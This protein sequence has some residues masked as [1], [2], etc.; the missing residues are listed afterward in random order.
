[1]LSLLHRYLE[2]Y[3][4][5]GRTEVQSFIED[6]EGQVQQIC[7][8]TGRRVK[9]A[10]GKKGNLCISKSI[11]TVYNVKSVKNPACKV[12]S[13]ELRKHKVVVACNKVQKR[14]LPVHYEKY[15]DQEP[16]NLTCM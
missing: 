14:C 9:G 7:G 1:M 3:H 15:S 13:A 5:C 12:N 10:T 16:D 4:L 8:S 2:K 11:M 6:G